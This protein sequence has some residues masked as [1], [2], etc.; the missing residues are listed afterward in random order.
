MWLHEHFDFLKIEFG[1][2]MA[3]GVGVEAEGVLS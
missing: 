1:R 3:R 2:Q